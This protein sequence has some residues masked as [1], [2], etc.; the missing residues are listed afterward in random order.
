MFWHMIC[1]TISAHQAKFHGTPVTVENF[2]EWRRKFEQEMAIERGG[3]GKDSS[4]QTTKLT[5]GWG[6]K[7]YDLAA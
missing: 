5:G 6:Q 1:C 7:P 2:M 4:Q 3:K